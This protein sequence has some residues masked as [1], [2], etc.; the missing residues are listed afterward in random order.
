MTS[1]RRGELVPLASI[2]IGER[3]RRD[4]G[5]LSSLMRSIEA[6]GVLNPPVVRWDGARFTL[7]AGHRRLEALRG[8][9]W[10][11][12]P[13]SLADDATTALEALLM[14][15]EAVAEGRRIEELE[16][17]AAKE[18]QAANAARSRAVKGGSE[19]GNLPTSTEPKR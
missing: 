10:V 8:L 12:I 1:L 14:E 15:R 13:V 6:V 17:A 7:V 9:G 16:R 19:V 5:D 3:S 18:R 2:S 11:D 4:L